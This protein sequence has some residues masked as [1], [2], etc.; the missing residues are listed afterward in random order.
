M[1][2]VATKKVRNLVLVFGDQ[3]DPDAG[4]FKDFDPKKDAVWMAEVDHE[5]TYVWSHKQR[6]ALF[7]SAMRHFRDELSARGI[8]VHYRE[9][10]DKANS[11]K[12]STE[13][14]HALETLKPEKVHFT[15]PGEWRILRGCEKVLQTTDTSYQLFEDTHFFTAPADFDEHAEGRKSLRMEFFYREL[16][17]KTGILMDEDGKPV[18]G[19]WNFDKE[20]RGSFGK[21]GPPVE[22]AGP[23]SEPDEITAEVL[24]LVEDHFPKHPGSL[25]HFRWPV[26]RRAA[27][28]ALND[29]VK[30]RL[31][32]FGTY[33][34]AMWTDAPWLY[35]AWLGSSLNLKL[36][37]PREVVSAAEA[38]YHEGH[39]PLPA[40]E[41]FI[42]QILGWREYVRGVYWKFMPDYLERNS[43]GADAA[44]PDFY[45]T[46]DTEYACLKQT[47]GQTLEYGYAHHIQRLMV[48]GLYALLLGVNPKAVHEW[49]L[50]VYV[51]AVEW[52]ELPNVLGM[53][54]YADGGVMASKPY[55]ATGKYIQRMSNYCAKCPKNPAK[56]TGEDA[57]PF[58]TLYWDF[59]L[60]NEKPLRRNQ[61]M[62]LQVRNID[63]IDEAERS[64]IRA[65]AAKLKGA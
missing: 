29:F 1:S 31:P 53:S 65:A 6:I 26:T 34:D 25:K 47:I 54:Q 35:H 41:G 49:Y 56:R 10:G 50:A 18:G 7:L 24:R 61:R 27:L 43:L 60:R 45:W 44:L 39:A 22:T 28:H 63:R 14:E 36:L 4:V 21:G 51:D 17:K 20:N 9:L 58:T 48:T 3:L 23:V 13:L 8:K 59:L 15:R 11:G 55:A 16:R 33:Q 30:H 46:G 64:E 42:R 2:A 52:V 40:V 57:C 19:E 37:N 32:D 12:L 38:A 5:S 62:S